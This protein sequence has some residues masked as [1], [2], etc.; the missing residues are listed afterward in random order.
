MLTEYFSARHSE[1]L[2]R[3]PVGSL[4]DGFTDWLAGRGYLPTVIQ[5]KVRD[6]VHFAAWTLSEG[7]WSRIRP[8][9]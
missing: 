4:L 3:G 2:R 5:E 7:P 9:T 8:E 1:R 6:T